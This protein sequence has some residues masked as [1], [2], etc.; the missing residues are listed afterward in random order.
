MKTFFAVIICAGTGA[1]ATSFIFWASTALPHHN[2]AATIKQTIPI[3]I[4]NMFPPIPLDGRPLHPVPSLVTLLHHCSTHTPPRRVIPTGVP[5]T[6]RHAVEGS[7]HHSNRTS[8]RCSP[9][10][11]PYTLSPLHSYTSSSFPI[12]VYSPHRN[13]APPHPALRSP[14]HPR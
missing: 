2:V 11:N 3:R 7:W 14:P 4:F 8:P 10:L 12:R 5:R 13:E 1:A 9:L 6:L